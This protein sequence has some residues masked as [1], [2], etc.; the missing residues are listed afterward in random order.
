M[1]IVVELEEKAPY[2]EYSNGVPIDNDMYKSYSDT[3]KILSDTDSETHFD[4]GEG[5]G[6]FLLFKTNLP[7]F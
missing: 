3:S 7:K 6:E 5:E 4:Y 1:K 2:G